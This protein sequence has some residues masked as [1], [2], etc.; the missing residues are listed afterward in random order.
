MVS[1][2]RT[3]QRLTAMSFNTDQAKRTDLSTEQR[4]AVSEQR[5][6][7]LAENARDVVWSMSPSGEITDISSA[8]EKLRDITH[9]EAM[10][11][12]LDP[13]LTPPSQTLII[14]YYKRLHQAA[15]SGQPLPTY[16][17]DLEYYRKDGTTFWTDVLVCPI[18][19]DRGQLVEVLGVTRDIHEREQY[20]DSL[21]D[22][23]AIAELA[24]QAKSKFLAHVS[25]EMR[26]P[27]SS[28]LSWLHLAGEQK[29]DQDQAELIG[30]A[31]QAGQLLLGIINDL[32]DLSRLKQSTLTIDR[33]SLSLQS[34]LTQVEDLTLPLCQRQSSTYQ[35]VVAHNVPDV[36]VYGSSRH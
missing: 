11:Q 16:R 15:I 30:K 26:T 35:S 31:Q 32:L 3:D 5:H 29:T 13:I 7:I 28:L 1:P 2:A 27:L 24:N 23:R 18:T 34:V 19:D 25:H 14:D 22:A 8:I 33:K 12:T 36:L 17:G 20:E 10:A 9:K 4:L 6:L 21:K